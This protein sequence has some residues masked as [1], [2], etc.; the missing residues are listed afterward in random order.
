MSK[1]RLISLLEEWGFYK[2]GKK[3]STDELVY[4]RDFMP[5]FDITNP[6]KTFPFI[7]LKEN[8]N[9]FIVPIKPDYHTELLPDSILRTESQE[10]FKKDKPHRNAISKVYNSRSFEKIYQK[11]RHYFIL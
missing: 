6:K 3:E 1:K 11:R 7:S 10:D 2:W 5:K 4:V 9:F 8:N